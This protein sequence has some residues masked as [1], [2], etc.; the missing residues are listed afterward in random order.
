MTAAERAIHAIAQTVPAHSR[1][2]YRE[3]WLADV[4]G[5]PDLGIAPTSVVLGAA[6]T[7]A[8]QGSVASLKMRKR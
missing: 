8:T 1:P 5:A 3:E 7:A 4:A 6:A 2:R